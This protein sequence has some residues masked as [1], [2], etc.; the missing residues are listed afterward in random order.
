MLADE[1]A[2]AIR[3]LILKKCQ[4]VVFLCQCF[5]LSDSVLLRCETVMQWGCQKTDGS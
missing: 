1:K 2:S 4:Q 3:D 5:V